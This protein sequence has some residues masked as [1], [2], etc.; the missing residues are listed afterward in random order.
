MW[1]VVERYTGRVGYKGGVKAEGLAANP[2]VIDCSGWVSLLLS[3]AMTAVN[4]SLGQKVFSGD[5]VAAVFT[6]SDRIIE[7]IETRTATI[8]EGNRITIADLPRYATI[9][10]RQGGGA[11]AQ[12]HPRPRGITHIVQIVRRPGDGAPFVSEAQGWAEPYGLRLLPLSD[13]LDMTQAYLKVGESWAV[14]PFTK[15][16][17]AVV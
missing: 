2:P 8:L 4:D 1:Q 12:N 15:L 9:G 14:D 11:W 17:H 13:W 3:T 6:W 7:A 5:D 16:R 10:L